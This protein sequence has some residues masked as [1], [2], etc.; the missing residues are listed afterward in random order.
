MLTDKYLDKIRV[1]SRVYSFL[2]D[3]Y[4]YKNKPLEKLDCKLIKGFY[5]RVVNDE[6]LCVDPEEAT[7]RLDTRRDSLAFGLRKM[8]INSLS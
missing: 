4:V 5:R 3:P 2:I 8:S 1:L 6:K 7:K